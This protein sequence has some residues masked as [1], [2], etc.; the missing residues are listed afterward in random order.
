[1][2]N[3]NP[4]EART[5]VVQGGA[6]GEHQFSRVQCEGKDF[7]LDSSALAFALAPGAGSRITLRMRRYANPPTFAFPWD[8]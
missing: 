7:A 2:V 5:V 1:L 3:L 8:R 6:Y 4:A